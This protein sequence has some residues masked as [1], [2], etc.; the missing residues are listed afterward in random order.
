MLL[1]I[2][3]LY[4]VFCRGA[5]ELGTVKVIIDLWPGGQNISVNNPSLT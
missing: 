5:H 4:L 3:N 2:D 1:K